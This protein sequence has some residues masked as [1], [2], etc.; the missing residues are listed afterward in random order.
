MKSLVLKRSIKIAGQ[1]T[2]VSLEDGF[3][4]GLRDI[5]EERG[6]SL[7]KL[8]GSINAGR[9]FSNLSSAIRLFVLGFYQARYDQ[10]Q[11]IRH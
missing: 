10:R 7:S 8:I 3:W 4:N 6:E 2:S 9:Q 1:Q 11:T 5:A